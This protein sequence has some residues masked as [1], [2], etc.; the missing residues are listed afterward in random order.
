MFV[1]QFGLHI[2]HGL[3]MIWVGLVAGCVA[4]VGSGVT[5]WVLGILLC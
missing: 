1:T 3:A 2:P 4:E 5:D